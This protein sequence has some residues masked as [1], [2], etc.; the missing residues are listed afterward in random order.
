M[1]K[2]CKLC[3]EQ[4]E[5]NGNRKICFKQHY[6]TCKVCGKQYPI[7]STQFNVCC[8]KECSRKLRKQNAEATSLLRYGVKNAGYTKESQEKIKKTNLERFGTEYAF[9]SDTL[10]EKIRRSNLEKYGVDNP[11]KSKEIQEKAKATNIE[12]YGAECVLGTGSKI[13]EQINRESR[14]KFG[15]A[16]GFGNTPEATSKR[17][18]T[19]EER[20]GVPWVT[21]SPEVAEKRAET[22]RKKFGF[23]SP[24]SSKQMQEKIKQSN[25]DKYGVPYPMQSEEVKE[26]YRQLFHKKYGVDWG[27]MLPQYIEAVGNR[28]SKINKLFGAFLESHGFQVEYEFPIRNKQ[29]DIKVDRILIEIDPTYTHTTYEHIDSRYGPIDKD[30]HLQKTLVAQENGYRCIHVFNWDDWDDILNYIKYE[31]SITI[32]DS[33]KEYICDNAKEDYRDFLKLGFKIKS[34]QEPRRIWSKD[35]EILSGD[36]DEEEL[37]AHGWLPIYDCGTTLLE[38]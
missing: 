18:K 26:R 1:L 37:L 8:S 13:R 16:G 10:K 28:I 7:N 5:Y 31:P 33:I 30:Y 32:D 34:V 24:F 36:V 29:Y 3:G 35:K 2:T 25:I 38:R 6:Y 9:Q 22:C 11:M 17:M 15:N 23:D 20:Y 27:F 14:E 21:Q 12:R 4:F 19:N